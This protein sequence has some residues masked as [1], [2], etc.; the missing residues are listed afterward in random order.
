MVLV[1]LVLITVEVLYREQNGSGY[2]ISRFK[3][4]LGPLSVMVL[5][6]LLLWS[7]FPNTNHTGTNLIK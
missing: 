5:S 3:Y 6:A 2:L 7:P 1:I 4:F